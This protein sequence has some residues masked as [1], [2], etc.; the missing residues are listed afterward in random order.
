MTSV[1]GPGFESRCG[2]PDGG[3]EV[4]SDGAVEIELM[5]FGVS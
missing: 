5:V 2:R 3:G 1:A 4:P